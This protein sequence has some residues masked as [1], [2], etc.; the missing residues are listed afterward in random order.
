MA[1]TIYLPSPLGKLEAKYSA[2]GIS[3]LGLLSKDNPMPLDD[4]ASLDA[5]GREIAGAIAGYFSG[6]KGALDTLKID[7]SGATPFQLTVYAALRKVAWGQAL[8]YGDLASAVGKPLAARAIGAAVAR[9]PLMFIIPC[10]RVLGADGKMHGFSAEGGLATK[11]WLLR[12]EGHAIE[13]GKLVLAH[14]TPDEIIEAVPDYGGFHSGYAALVGRPNAGK[15]TLLNRLLGQPI[16]GVSAKPQTTRRRQLGILTTDKA[17]I[18]FLDTPGFHDPIDKLSE[19]INAEA[20]YALADADI[21][22]FLADSTAA[23]DSVDR[24]MIEL[25]QKK[26]RDH[27]LLV[28]TKQDLA[29]EKSRL[30]NEHSYQQLLPDVRTLRISAETGTGVDEFIAVLEELLPE[31]P[32]YYPEEQVTE[33]FERDIAAEMIRASAME[34]LEDEL[35]YSLAVKVLEFTERSNGDVYILAAIFVEREAQKGI[36]IGKSGQM[37]KE[38]GVSARK[39]IEKMADRKVFLS[40]DVKVQKDWKNNPFF[41]KEMGL[42]KQK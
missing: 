11:E 4:I 27:V 31:G 36:L 2:D 39:A 38:I 12:H 22:A 1:K 7:I 40:L 30:T 35:P 33:D 17:Q 13:N 5:Q 18:I 32:R 8:S 34:K 28:M 6:D 15:S 25:L 42:A 41:L 37:I 29:D 3:S 10:H 9:N 16:A 14:A 19:F 21:V 23:P 24:K 26:P 20:F